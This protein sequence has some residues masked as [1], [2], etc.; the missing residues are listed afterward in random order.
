MEK[1]KINQLNEGFIKLTNRLDLAGTR[2]EQT[3][4]SIADAVATALDVE[5]VSIWR[6]SPSSMEVRCLAAHGPKD[7]KMPREW[8]DLTPY[9]SYLL[10]LQT[11][12]SV[13]SPNVNKDQRLEGL[14]KEYWLSPAVK[15]SLHIP[16]RAA[17]KVHGVLRV[18]S[19]SEKMWDQDEI[20]F[21]QRMA[22]LV[23]QAF[24]SEEIEAKTRRMDSVRSLS[25]DLNHDFNLTSLLDELVRKAADALDCSRAALYLAD[26]E[27]KVLV[28]AAAYKVPGKFVGQILSYGEDLAGKV[29]ETGQDLFVTD[30]RTWAGRTQKIGKDEPRTAILSVPLR[31]RGEVTGVIQVFRQDGALPFETPDRDVLVQFANLAALAFEKNRLTESGNRLKQFQQS[32][33]EIINVTKQMPS[34]EDCLEAAA[35]YIIQSM[36]VPSVVLRVNETGVVRGLPLGADRQIEAELRK[37]GRQFDMTTTVFNLDISD[38]S[39]PE[40]AAVIKRLDAKSFVLSPIKI[41]RD[42]IGFICLASQTPRVWTSE[43]VKMAEIAGHQIGLAIEAMHFHHE[44]SSFMDVAERLTSTTST[45]NRLVSLDEIIPMIGQGAVRLSNADRLAIILREQDDKVRA[46]WVFGMP[47]PEFDRI[48][49]QDGVRLLETFKDKPAPAQY[50]NFRNA[51]I[52]QSLTRFLTGMG[53]EAMR[54]TPILHSGN[55]VGV[56]AAFDESPRDWHHWERETMTTFANTASLALQSIWLYEQLE[57]G[58]LDLALSLANTV[59]AR[60]NDILTISMRLAEWSQYTAR[61]LGLSD[62]DTELVRWAALLHDIGKVE[63]PDDVIRKPGPL[64]DEERKMLEHYPVK[65]EK[66]LSSSSRYQKVGKVLRY[67]RERYDGKGYPDKKK[68]SDIP[69]PA[70]ILAVADAYGSMIGNRPYRKAHS[71]DDAV[72]ELMKNSGTQFDPEVVNAFLQAVSHEAPVH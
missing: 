3:S 44:I 57:K 37:R 49:E 27:Q 13:V 48:I 43:E 68:G 64:T 6:F 67:L 38:A 55:V 2:I 59:D 4:M 25:I 50:P 1:N 47:K 26:T 45:L 71:H 12:L 8:L 33:S 30:Y 52:P 41:N 23:S 46:S 20:H 18:E 10:A 69:L 15:S 70:R 28:G 35:D 56:I 14:P 21:C 19:R 31:M 53:V 22:D 62:E 9:A 58:Y 54:M 24:L 66:L 17:N 34:D 29:A 40:M 60:E 39:Y 36:D 42:R 5:H 63:V 61:L 11:E 51:M 65:S 32:L 16:V 7:I 72:K